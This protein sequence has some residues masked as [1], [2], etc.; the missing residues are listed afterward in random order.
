MLFESTG[1]LCDTVVVVVVERRLCF[2][3]VVCSSLFVCRVGLVISGGE[4]VTSQ[5]C[6]VARREQLVQYVADCIS[7]KIGE[8]VLFP[9]FA[10]CMDSR[11]H[12]VGLGTLGG[13]EHNFEGNAIVVV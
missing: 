5:R 3:L 13:F 4:A 9:N 10:G 8:T 7:A 11:L 6:C 1:Y 12:F 2:V